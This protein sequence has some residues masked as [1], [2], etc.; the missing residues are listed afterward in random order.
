MLT[1]P[2]G[3]RFFGVLKG[4]CAH[5]VQKESVLQAGSQET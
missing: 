4:H 3:I 5:Q 1:E 2:D